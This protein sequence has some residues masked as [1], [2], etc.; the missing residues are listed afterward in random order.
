[1]IDVLYDRA[2]L[3]YH[4]P[5]TIAPPFRKSWI[6]HCTAWFK[7]NQHNEAA[8]QY[9][10]TQI[11]THFIFKQTLRKW[12]DRKKG[13]NKVIAKMHSVSPNDSERFYLRMLLLHIPGA[14]SFEDLRTVDGRT[15]ET[16]HEACKL[17]HLLAD[18]SEWDNAMSE[19]STFQMTRQLRVL[20]ATICS[21]SE[22]Q[23]PLQLWL[24]HKE[25][26]IEDY[27]QGHALLRN[28]KRWL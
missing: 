5:T 12:E 2:F 13:G 15:A 6:R 9:L 21:H 7:L 10:Y 20:Y 18:D 14:T 16:F 28:Q 11:P 4:F 23:N 22:P 26:L 25:H 17:K 3:V 27:T 19:A 1:M 8:R 24:N